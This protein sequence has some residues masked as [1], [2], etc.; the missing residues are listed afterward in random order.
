[1]MTS[2]S[3]CRPANN[4]SMLLRLPKVGPQLPKDHCTGCIPPFAPER[5]KVCALSSRQAHTDTSHEGKTIRRGNEHD[6][7]DYHHVRTDPRARLAYRATIHY[8][9]EERN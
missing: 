1:M 3:K 7:A 9:R 4:S 8:Q 6:E 2:R 5:G